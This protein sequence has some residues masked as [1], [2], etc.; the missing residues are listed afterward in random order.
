MTSLA[1]YE[2]T[3]ATQE[4]L[5]AKAVAERV[6][7]FWH[8]AGYIHVTAHAE[9][10]PGSY[11]VGDRSMLWT[12]RSNLIGGLPPGVRGDDVARLYRAERRWG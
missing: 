11:E 3:H 7:R 6:R 1:R 4:E 9:R 8:L 5:D 2:S 12:V 10:V